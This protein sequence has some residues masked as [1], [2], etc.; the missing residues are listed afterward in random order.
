MNTPLEQIEARVKS[1]DADALIQLLEM[2]RT[3]LLGFVQHLMSKSLQQKVDAE[4]VIQEVC[5]SCVNSF[6]EVDLSERHPFDWVC[7][8][9]RRRII[10]Q[11][12][13]YKGTEKRAIDREIGMSGGSTDQAA[14][15]QMLIAS[16]T[17]PSSA[18]SR[19]QREFR[20]QQAIEQLPQENR[21]AIRM[22]YVESLPSK[23]IAERLGKSDGAVRVL[24]TRSL[25][26]LQSLIGDDQ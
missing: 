15:A 20:L 25:K 13:K 7:Q 19:D 6:S 10:D 17:S 8:V 21:D 22:R 14:F 24:L 16:I 12:R 1:G 9:A 26:R 4:D 18:F 23:E 2:Y 5:L 11:G 3:R